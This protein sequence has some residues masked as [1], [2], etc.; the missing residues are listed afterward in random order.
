MKIT[1]DTKSKPDPFAG[2]TPLENKT[3]KAAIIFVFAGVFVWAVK[4][5]ILA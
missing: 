2:L 5:L 3:R 1:P 4:I